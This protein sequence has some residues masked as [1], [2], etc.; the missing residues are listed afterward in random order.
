[1][2]GLPASGG[3]GEGRA[4][5]GDGMPR[6]V[7]EGLLATLA[8]RGTRR[9]W[10]V[11]GGGSSLDLIA[12]ADPAGLDF[13]LCRH[14]G[15]AAMMAVADAELTGAPGVVL[16]TK[17]PGLMN[18]ANGLACATLERAPVMLVSDGFT[19]AQLAYITHQVFDQRD[20]TAAVVKGYARGESAAEIGALLDD[21]VADPA[22]AVHLDLTSAAAKR[23]MPFA[24]PYPR[25]A[26]E[27]ADVAPVAALLAGA[28]RPVMVLGLEAARIDAAPVRAL[29]EALGCPVLATY[30]AKGVVPDGHRLFVG[31]FTGGT[32]EADCVAAADL[33]LLVGL[34]PVE[35]ILQPW[36]HAAPVAELAAR[37]FPVHYVTPAAGAYGCLATS[38]AALRTGV[39]ASDWRAEEIAA[40]RDTMRAA[41]AW[42]GQGGVAPPRIVEMAAEA[43]ARAGRH[44]RASVDAGAHMFSATAFWPCHA[45]RDLLISNGLASMGF[46]LP[47]AIAAALHDPAR[48][49]VA[50]TGDGGL[51]MCLAEL[52]TAAERRARMVTIVFNDGA[53]SLIDVKQQQRQLAPEGVRWPRAD[54]A[55]VAEGL[56]AR[57]FRAADEAALAAA[58]DAA[59]A[60]D[61]P[62]LVDVLVEPAGYLRQLQAMRG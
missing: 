31:L 22:G 2:R 60:H 32:L 16:T 24:V 36:R 44:P 59:L 45:P 9:I 10:G 25:G 52:A 37:P 55:A 11:P 57:G 56:G 47:A 62:S 39:R 30:K 18:A 48:G 49:A 50:F 26:S 61:G 53:L 14:E 41:L 58:L 46:A 19:P 7:A 34:D 42:Q 6:T 5:D 3:S 43:A 20:A 17:G 1:M 51:M 38:V 23:V 40:H 8:A 13:V 29:A 33:I 21:A 12:G 15:S 28:R 4:M 35:L 54:F 27:P